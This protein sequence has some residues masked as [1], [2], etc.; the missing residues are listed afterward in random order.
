[1]NYK[2]VVCDCD[3]T[4]I[5][6]KGY[7][8]EDNIKAI[9]KI[10]DMGVKFVIAT[11]RNDLLV[12]DYAD[13]IGG[14][15]TLIGCNGATIRNI[16][17]GITYRNELIPKNSLKKILEYLDENNL[18][19]KAYTIEESFA[20]GEGL[21]GKNVSFSGNN[22]EN[23]KDFKAAVI[24]K[25]SEITD[26][27]ILKVVTIGK[28]ADLAKIQAN[29][30]ETEG[31]NV[32]FSSEICID[33][34]SDKASKGSALACLAEKMNIKPSEII[35]FG[36]SENDL[37]MLKYAGFSVC[38]ENGEDEIKKQCSMVTKTNNQAG[39]AFALDKIFGLNMY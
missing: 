30:R 24:E 9:R 4:L 36:D 1:M 14:D 8:P 17:R 39:V 34:I 25:G 29:L 5:D 7:L 3:N 16:R 37:S 28:K 11:G 12:L 15:I 26:C 32:V 13:E 23:I 21:I 33:M 2:L 6:R 38:M 35:A 22:Y 18:G 20:R 19:F 27:D 31:V 10:M